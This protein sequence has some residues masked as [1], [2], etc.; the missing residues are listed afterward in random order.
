M[1]KHDSKNFFYGIVGIFLLLPAMILSLSGIM[2]SLFDITAISKMVNFQSL[3]FH[4]SAILG[5]IVFSFGINLFAILK[6]HISRKKFHLTLKDSPGFL[7]VLVV[8]LSIVLLGTIFLY[9][10]VENLQVS[11]YVS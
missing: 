4:P 11:V 6:I 3:M 1:K 10:L 8:L 9:L 7:N 2:Q 5:G